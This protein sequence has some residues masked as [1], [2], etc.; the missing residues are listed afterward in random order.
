M[1]SKDSE[2]EAG[3]RLR[4]VLEEDLERRAAAL[5]GT[6]QEQVERRAAAAEVAA[7]L[8]R[9]DLAAVQRELVSVRREALAAGGGAEEAA[10]TARR[11]LERLAAVE[12]R[13]VDSVGDVPLR[14]AEA[15]RGADAAA[16]AVQALSHRVNAL[17]AA[18]AVAAA[19]TDSDSVG[20]SVGKLGDQVRLSLSLSLTHTHLN[21]GD[22]VRLSP[23]LQPIPPPPPP[24]PLH[25]GSV[26][27]TG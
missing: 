27:S 1:S 2:A 3:R 20:R 23:P 9:D 15:Q 24:P 18:A 25:R 5:A 12:G 14:V 16:A 13:C 7:R 21:R 22:Q 19:G 17:A 10:A 8:V 11:A 26:A 4:A 6:V